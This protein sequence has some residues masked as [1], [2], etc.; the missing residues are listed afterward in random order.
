MAQLEIDPT[1]WLL[2]AVWSKDAD[3]YDASVLGLE[4]FNG[5]AS[6]FD[7]GAGLGYVLEMFENQSIQRFGAI[8]RKIEAKHPVEIAQGAGALNDGI[9]SR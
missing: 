7:A 5:Y 1:G 9:A 3:S 2:G 6:Q 4:D 8:Y